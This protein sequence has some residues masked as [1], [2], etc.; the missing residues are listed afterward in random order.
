M[1]SEWEDPRGLTHAHV[2]AMEEALC[3]LVP[4]SKGKN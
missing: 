4:P 2:Q 3:W 1:E